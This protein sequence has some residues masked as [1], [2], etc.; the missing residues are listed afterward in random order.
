[1]ALSG[2]HVNADAHTMND[3]TTNS[4]A[5][6]VLARAER[7]LATFDRSRLN[8]ADGTVNVGAYR[9]LDWIMKYR[10]DARRDVAR[11][12]GRTPTACSSSQPAACNTTTPKPASKPAQA[13]CPTSLAE[14][15]ELTRSLV[16]H[17]PQ[18]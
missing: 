3:N 1:M 10:D 16:T 5:A 14:A 18:Q 12:A 4:N 2:A 17:Q 11:S 6:E 9:E 13:A 8:N 15:V 7:A